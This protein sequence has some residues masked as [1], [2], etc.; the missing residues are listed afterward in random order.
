MRRFQMVTLFLFCLATILL[1]RCTQNVA[2]GGSESGNPVVAG[3]ILNE[4]G[5]VVNNTQV[6][7]IPSNY[8]P[9]IDQQPPDS[10]IDTTDEKGYYSFTLS[11]TSGVYNIEGV[12][13]SQRTKVLVAGIHV[14][15]DTTVAQN[16]VLKVPG[17]IKL[18]LPDTI[19]TARGYL[20]L[21]GT[22]IY[23]FLSGATPINDGGYEIT[24]DS[25]PEG[26][27]NA[28]NYDVVNDSSE[29]VPLTGSVE[30]SSND[31]TLI[32]LLLRWIEYTKDNSQ[33]PDN[34]INDI[35]SSK[36]GKIWFAT[37]GGLACIDMVKNWI[38]YD[39]G[40]SD[41]PS[42]SV[43]SLRHVDDYTW[44]ATYGGA[45]VLYKDGW[46]IYDTGNSD[47]PSN[48]I[49]CLDVG[50]NGEKW[51]GTLDQGL[52]NYNNTSWI[53]YDTATS[54][55]PSNNVKSVKVDKSGIVWCLTNKGVAKIDGTIWQIYTS[56]NTSLFSDNVYCMAI[57]LKGDIWIGCHGG[58]SRFDGNVWTTYDSIS[59]PLLK[60]S[61]LSIAVDL[62]NNIWVGTSS[63]LTVFSGDKWIDYTGERYKLL[64]NASIRSIGFDISYH[65]K[66]IGTSLKGVIAFGPTLIF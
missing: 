19:D 11:E 46:T 3:I 34:V 31:I 55:L 5:E 13:L 59:S 41:L 16:G 29:P 42:N 39:T 10:M 25:A 32:D 44:C 15:E 49:T 64:N 43:F 51:F 56:S 54:S 40:N 62:F 36:D 12:H 21:E 14:S 60:D 65:N 2:G 9:V 20:Y 24:L 61:V 37:Y 52:A 17:T 35:S 26:T 38:T 18:F 22:T 6:K 8:N 57:D 48:Y 63:G 27:I 50:K 58:I 33:L 45:A 7:L 23:N 28:I 53:T 30:V 4:N 47:I 1:L 66:W